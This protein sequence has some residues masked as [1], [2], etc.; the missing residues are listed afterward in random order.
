MKASL[1]S[2]SAKSSVMSS[3]VDGKIQLIAAQIHSLEVP[4]KSSQKN[5]DFERLEERS[6]KVEAR[7]K[8]CDELHQKRV[9]LLGE[10][11]SKFTKLLEEE[12]SST[13]TLYDEQIKRITRLEDKMNDLIGNIEKVETF[14]RRES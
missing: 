8:E 12:R 2:S 6:R 4:M 1:W 10:T 13:E 9:A 14:D 11:L 3:P 5:K 7:V